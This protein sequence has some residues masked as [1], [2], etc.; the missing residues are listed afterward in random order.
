MRT[1]EH[2]HGCHPR[3]SKATALRGEGDPGGKNWPS[4]AAWAPFPRVHRTLAG[5]NKL[6]LLITTAI[7]LTAVPAVADE[8][9]TDLETVVITATRT[10]QPIDKTG[11]S[12]T[13]ITAEDIKVQQIDVVTDI[14][15]ETPG[16]TV[17]RNGGTGQLTTISIR[18]AETGQSVVLIDG[19]RINGVDLITFDSDDQFWR[20][21]LDPVGATLQAY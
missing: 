6:L 11:S 19:I 12:I 21:S 16:L 1:R 10:P 15:A 14:L 9:T 8:S 20:H 2:S 4:L 7:C 18:G 3:P 5:G 17:N 13:V